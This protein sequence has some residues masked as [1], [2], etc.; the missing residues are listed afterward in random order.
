M[1]EASADRVDLPSAIGRYEI[2]SRLSVDPLHEVYLGFDP[3]IERPVAVKVF[4]LRHATPEAIAGVRETFG[5][6]MARAGVLSHP[7]IVSL[8]DAG[9]WPGGLFVANEYIEGHNLRDALLSSTE[10]DLPL[11]VSL[12]VQVVDALEHA[13]E[14]E[15]PHLDLKPSNIFVAADDML[16][17]GGFGVAHVG[18]SLVAALGRPRRTTRYLAPERA[19]G[20]PGDFRS[21]AYAIAQI[22]LDILAGPDRPA[23]ADGWSAAPPVPPS[24]VAHGVRADRWTTLFEHA[25]AEDPADRFPTA[26]IFSTELLM[27]LELSES[28]ARLALETSRAMG[29]LAISDASLVEAISAAESATV[30]RSPPPLTPGDSTTTTTTAAATPPF[31]S[32][33]ADAETVLGLPAHRPGAPPATR[34]DE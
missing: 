1:S 2:R 3:L 12:L 27:R 5:R 7:G 31:E 20:A 18:D 15:V 16:K 23:P 10:R 9:E 13:R 6:E 33:H 19:A 29:A 24:L 11:L 32:S 21:D 17:V 8:Y 26:G 14:L 34:G 25:L 28:E 30:L 22:A 4:P